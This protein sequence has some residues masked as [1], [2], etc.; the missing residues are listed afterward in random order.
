M[1]AVNKMIDDVQAAYDAKV[2]QI[3]RDAAAAKMVAR[4]EAV[5]SIVS[6]FK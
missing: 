5:E 4:E 2:E 3:D 1:S 6:K